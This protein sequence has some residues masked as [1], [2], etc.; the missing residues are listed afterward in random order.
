MYWEVGL[1]KRPN[2]YFNSPQSWNSYSYVINNPLNLVDPTGE[3]ESAWDYLNPF[4]LP[5][6]YGPSVEDT[7]T[8]GVDR[9][10]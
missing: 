6:T 8:P 10:A 9:N 7:Q 1:T 4:Y 5:S 2:Q 3:Q